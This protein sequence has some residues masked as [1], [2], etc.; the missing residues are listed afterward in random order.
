VWSKWFRSL[1]RATNQPKLWF[2][3]RS[4]WPD[5]PVTV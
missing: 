5:N 2:I 4:V 1:H 3:W